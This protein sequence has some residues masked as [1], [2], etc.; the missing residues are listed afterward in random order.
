M[1]NGSP[2]RRTG[3]ASFRRNLAIAA[4][5]TGEHALAPQLRAWVDAADEGLRAAATWALEKLRL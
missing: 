4:A 2:V 5:N 1:F 3:F